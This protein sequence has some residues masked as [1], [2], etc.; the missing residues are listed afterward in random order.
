MGQESAL[1]VGPRPPVV[2]RGREEGARV[3]SGQSLKPPASS[4]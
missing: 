3:G 1:A 2:L 4:R